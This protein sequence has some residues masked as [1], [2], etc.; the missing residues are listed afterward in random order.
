MA[1]LGAINKNTMS[2]LGFSMFPHAPTWERVISCACIIAH[3]WKVVNI[4]Q[5]SYDPHIALVAVS[6]RL[7]LVDKATK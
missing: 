6:H 3:M 7:A 1:M 5:K 2:H 4:G